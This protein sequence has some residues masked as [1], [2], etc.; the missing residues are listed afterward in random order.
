MSLPYA[1]LC[2]PVYTMGREAEKK[3]GMA[4]PDSGRRDG[5]KGPDG[6]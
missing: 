5:V 1:M 3:H 4:L 6:L 2:A